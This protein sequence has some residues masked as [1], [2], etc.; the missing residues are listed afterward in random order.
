M[1]AIF[2]AHKPNQIPAFHS[3]TAP[4][5]SRNKL[6]LSQNTITTHCAAPKMGCPFASG[7]TT[8][9]LRQSSTILAR[10][11]DR[12]SWHGRKTDEDSADPLE[13]FS[14]RM[15]FSL[16]L[17]DG[18]EIHFFTRGADTH[19]LLRPGGEVRGDGGIRAATRPI[20]FFTTT[21]AAGCGA[22]H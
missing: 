3:I 12:D 10:V 4:H 6:L 20:R 7:R 22:R 5:L 13:G 9:L 8:F 2:A 19:T 18:E 16:I 17:V 14:S 1:C 11:K 21:T 15:N